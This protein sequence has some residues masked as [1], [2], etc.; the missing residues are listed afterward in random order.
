MKI[1]YRSFPTEEYRFFTCDY[2][3]GET[4]FY[5]SVAER[6]EDAKSIIDS[7]NDGGWMEGVE[8]IFMGEVTH[9]TVRE[10]VEFRPERDDFESDEDFEAAMEEFGD[11]EWLYRCNY[12]MAP[13]E[14]TGEI[15][16]FPK[17]WTG[18]LRTTKATDGT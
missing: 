9:H 10:D 7:C 6:E 2:E 13:L 8:H 15:V 17:L 18:I 12:V 16:V 11:P 3:Q 5:K 14:E 4:R 1:D